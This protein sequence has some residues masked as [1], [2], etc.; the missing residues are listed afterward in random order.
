MTDEVH[1]SMTGLESCFEEELAR[2]DRHYLDPDHVKRS[3]HDEARPSMESKDNG[4]M[5]QAMRLNG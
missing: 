5:E 2:A 3:D 4:P 1:T